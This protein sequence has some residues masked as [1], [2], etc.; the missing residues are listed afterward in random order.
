MTITD[1]LVLI[2]RF[3]LAAYVLPSGINKLRHHNEFLDAL[4]NYNILSPQV[5]ARVGPV[6][7]WIE[8]ALGI[9]ILIGVLPALT[10]LGLIVLLAAFTTS[11]MI[12]IRRGRVIECGCDGMAG[13]KVI[14]WGAVARN[15]MLMSL[16]LILVGFPHAGWFIDAA[17][18]TSFADPLLILILV[19]FCI[20]FISL[21][22][23][24]IHMM[25]HAAFFQGIR[26]E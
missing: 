25:S 17:R 1:A 22:E 2:A 18:L 26:F 4:R 23:W 16:S 21:V 3:T 24:S 6:L 9:A 7:P 8:I 19:G 13:T 14:G 11:M 15:L 10:G 12:N 5:S 20:V